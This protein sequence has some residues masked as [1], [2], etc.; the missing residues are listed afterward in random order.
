MRSAIYKLGQLDCGASNLF[1]I[2]TVLILE[3]SK[4]DGLTQVGVAELVGVEDDASELNR[5]G[6][7]VKA[8]RFVD[9]NELAWFLLSTNHDEAVLE[10]LVESQSH[11]E[12]SLL[13]QQLIIPLLCCYR[14]FTSI[15]P[16]I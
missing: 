7:G 9:R 12:P 5:V 2:S 8:L 13:L 11:C 16:F 15:F 10:I 14:H 1:M 4:H 3:C 6:I